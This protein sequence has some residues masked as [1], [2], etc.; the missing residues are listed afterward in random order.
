MFQ[1]YLRLIFF[2]LQQD[3]KNCLRINRYFTCEYQILSQFEIQS[4]W[5]YGTNF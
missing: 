4:I 2:E 5:F 3:I 1:E